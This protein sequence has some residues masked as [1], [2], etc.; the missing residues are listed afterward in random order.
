[1]MFDP[2]ADALKDSDAHP[3]HSVAIIG[4]GI[5]GLTVAHELSRTG[6][7]DIT[8]YEQKASIGGKARSVRLDDQNVGE[9]AMRVFLASYCA[10][11]TVMQEIPYESQTTY[12]NLV[13][14]KF[15][16][17]YGK[18]DCSIDPKYTTFWNAIKKALLIS[19]FLH[20]AGVGMLEQI[21]FVYKIGRI[22]WMTPSQVDTEMSTL[23]F[24]DYMGGSSRSDAFRQIVL[25]VPEMLV[26]AKR[27]A[28]AA[29]A[30]PL[31]LEW[32]VGPFL[33]SRF[34]R[35]GFT[36]LNGPTSERFIDPWVELLTK[37][38]VRFCTN[39]RIAE[40]GESARLIQNVTTHDNQTIKADIYVLAVQHNVL[41]AL[42]DDR[43]KRLVPNLEDLLALGE[44]WSNG[45]QYFLKSIPPRWQ[46]YV[47][48]ITVGIDTEWSLVF[49]IT[50]ANELWNDVPL[51]AGTVGVLSVVL[52]NSRVNGRK[53]HK[54]Y[55][56]C[57]ADELLEETLVQIGW[58]EL[59]AIGRRFIGPD[60][61]YVE[62]RQFLVEQA[63][64]AGWATAAVPNENCSDAD[65]VAVSD[66]Q[67]YIRMPGNLSLEPENVTDV[68][69]LFVAGEFTKTNFA[70]PTMEK[71]CES[72][73]RC[74]HA[75]CL[76][77]DVPYDVTRFTNSA[78]LPFGFLRTL[79][80]RFFLFGF[81][82]AVIVLLW[83]IIARTFI[84]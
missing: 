70:K 59:N 29:V 66:S 64:Y 17:R 12:N 53:H 32:Y 5:A 77:H 38:G 34:H 33:K 9:H 41:R 25:R 14:S 16:L 79:K 50:T 56:R 49:L 45:V 19:R 46:R 7:F 39:V 74:A 48:R 8:I 63:Q 6:R 82:V 44:E 67:L 31:L 35:L 51:P 52:S 60:L 76:A 78:V 84:R 37:R 40:I 75:I 4:G 11:Y 68:Y 2:E 26:A 10:L 65:Q 23:S 30:A 15:S 42:L 24:E 71:A 61:H 18:L 57:T 20:R 47:G 62:H 13:Y 72:G 58:D 55:I 21:Y 81:G 3:R 22:L 43:L 83:I 28:S 69:N 73:M 80:W 36:S 1:M 54:P 27:Y